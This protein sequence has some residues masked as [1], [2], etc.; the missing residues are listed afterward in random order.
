[1][2]DSIMIQGTMSNSG[3]SFLTAGLCRIFVQDGIK[4]APFK[5]Q[6]MSN[7]SFITK[8]GLEIGTAQAL[9]AHACKILPASCMNPILLKPNSDTGS[10]VIVNG[11]V[12]GNMTAA[13]YYRNKQIFIPEILK[14]YKK[15]SDN[16]EAIVIEGAG[17][18]AEINLKENDIVNMGLAKL[19]DAPVILVA[20]ID[21]GGVFASIYG[22]IM[23][24]DKEERDRIKGIIINKFRGEVGIL[25]PGIRMIEEKTGKEVLGV[26][27]YKEIALDDEDS[28]SER[29]KSKDYGCKS[30]EIEKALKIFVIRFPHISNF[31]DFNIFERI[32]GVSLSYIDR[33]ELLKSSE[34]PDII[35]LPG[36]KNTM[37]DLKWLKEEGFI[38]KINSFLASGTVLIGICGGFQMLGNI[39]DDSRFT[40]H[41]GRMQGLRLLNFDTVFEEKKTRTDFKGNVN[42]E[43]NIF[44]YRDEDTSISGY[45]IHMGISIRNGEGIEF[46]KAED[47]PERL[48]AF[49]NQTGNV[50]GSYIHGLFENKI[51]TERMLNLTANKKIDFTN[52]IKDSKI[53]R[54]EQLDKLADLIRKNIN[55]DKVYN[56]LRR[57]YVY[58]A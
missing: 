38:S 14:A 19:V 56:I 23:L 12:Y 10:Q 7:N 11:L 47:N 15:L 1:M 22:T 40:E 8:E 55:M 45:E 6:N 48:V 37:H 16:Y 3:K 17:S 20:D 30:R 32:E 50:W 52:K 49:S 54:E 53:Y 26:L 46:I 29:L 35:I 13:E 58:K 28:L 43:N 31:N 2:A 9:Q 21:R 36:T 44:K 39:I 41:G 33:A 57:S 42:T 4:T 18:P 24:L 34:N 25:T 5:S 51:F 27:P